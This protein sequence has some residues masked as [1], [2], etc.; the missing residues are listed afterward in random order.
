MFKKAVYLFMIVFILI[1]MA[2]PAPRALASTY[3]V[4]NTNDSGLGSLRWAITQA[5]SNAG[6]DTIT[7]F[8]IGTIYL[9]SALPDLTDTA[10][11]TIDGG[12]SITIDGG[13]SVGI[14]LHSVSSQY[15]VI[16]NLTIQNF[17]DA[18]IEFLTYTSGTDG[19]H[20]V[21]NVTVSN[22]ATGIRIY[23]G[24]G[25]QV[26]NSTISSNSDYGIDVQWYS[27]VPQVTLTTNSVSHNSG[28]GIR[29]INEG[30]DGVVVD[31]NTVSYQ[32][33]HGIVVADG[34]D[35]TVL[36]GNMVS[37]NGDGTQEHGI[38]IKGESTDGTRIYGDNQ[39]AYN[40]G[41]GIT[42][43]DG[44]DDTRIYGNKIYN[45]GQV[46]SGVYA[47]SGIKV[48][49]DSTDNTLIG[50]TATDDANE[51]Y[52]NVGNGVSVQGGA[53]TG[54]ADT[55]ILGNK[56]YDN[57]QAT[58]DG[59]GIQIVGVV[60]DG[61][62]TD[63]YTVVIQNNAIYGNHSQGI[64]VEN[65]GTGSPTNCL[66]GG[67]YS[68]EGN[69]IY[70]NGQEGILLRD[71]GT[72]G[73]MIQGN[74]IGLS[75]VGGTLS[76]AAPNQ[77][78]GVAMTNGAQNNIL[79]GND[80][81]Y[82]VY[83]DVLLDGSGTSG[84][85]VRNNTILSDSDS[86]SHQYDNSGIVIAGE[87]SGNTIGSCNYIAYHLY[88]GVLILGDNADNNTVQGNNENC[89][90]TLTG[91]TPA[92]LGNGR[93]VSVVNH[94]VPSEAFGRV[95]ATHYNVPG[96]DGTTIS[97]NTIKANVGDGVYIKLTSNTSIESNDIQDNDGCGILWVGSTGGSIQGNSVEDNN[98]HGLRVEPHYGSSTSPDTS[99]DDI[100]NGTLLIG[101]TT[102]NAF[103]DNGLSGVYI[104]DDDIG[105]SA[106]QIAAR[107]TFSGNVDNEVQQ[108]WLGVVEI[109]Q[110]SGSSW[111]SVS[112]GQTVTIEGNGGSP[113]WSGSSYDSTDADSSRGVW[114]PSGLDYDDVD[115]WFT[116]TEE[117]VDNSGTLHTYTVHTVK[118]SG[119][120]NNDSGSFSYD[121]DSTSN[122]VSPDYGLP[123]SNDTSSSTTGRYQISQ[124][125]FS[126]TAIGFNGL[127]ASSGL[128]VDWRLM[129][130]V[131]LGLLLGFSMLRKFIFRRE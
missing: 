99:S 12:G 21:N 101:T 98:E 100:L 120:L 24:T 75:A 112:S 49:G 126:P 16:K 6:N 17:T 78:T 88:D 40:S 87:A 89:N 5:N 80:I 19:N 128:D 51:I 45:N 77:N 123:F 74:T 83:Q 2:F 1:I 53:S 113:V 15:N 115:T 91:D 23:N 72:N 30:A 33:D 105:A 52:Q 64:L 107:N 34:A 43:E 62:D 32:G 79:D 125:L 59:V 47:G 48:S 67:T 94:S 103:Q 117:I 11:V 28:I 56:I 116:I 38:Y 119:T 39:V 65:G 122:P 54:P 85:I 63:S 9:A 35:D 69:L 110:G 57:S 73:H 46:I 82:N 71:A 44:P 41:N 104:I 114:G 111:T 7:F 55:S 58:I 102:A 109:L 31:H 93:G 25:V 18:G 42:V 106:S 61:S 70:D 92:I 68:T 29:I 66:I 36:T 37:Y 4:W 27:G 20:E 130:L 86:S 124:L 14:G 3:T 84:N 108:D 81:A 10:G 8:T 95:D 13:S 76:D 22:C 129:F 97:S 26:I 118:T 121:G 90:Q 131:G 60:E 50:G 96:A 127:S